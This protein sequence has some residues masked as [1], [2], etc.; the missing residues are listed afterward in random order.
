MNQILYSGKSNNKPTIVIV[1]IVVVA[2]L[3]VLLIG[4]AI[5]N[6]FNNKILR[7]VF[8]DNI[9]LSNMTKEQAIEAISREYS[10]SEG[11]EI[12]LTFQ[13][14][15]IAVNTQDIGFMHSD[16]KEI[17]EEA[18]N[19]GRNKNIFSNNFTVL[20]SYFNAKK[21][22]DIEEKIDKERLQNLLDSSIS[23]DGIFS[24]DDYYKISGDK[25]LIVRGTEGRKIDYDKLEVLLIDAIKSNEIY[26]EI[27]V[28]VSE[29]KP[30]DI[31]DVYAKV[32][33]E[34]VNASYKEGKEFEIILE[35]N[36]I[37]FDKEEA[38]EKYEELKNGETAEI[39][40]VITQPE[41]K[42]SDLG[43]ILFRTLLATHTSTYDVNDTSR[44]AN[45]E[46]ASNRCNNTILYPG[47]EFSFNKALGNRTIENGYKMGASFSGGKVVNTIGGGIC[48]VSSTIYNAALR[49]DL[50]IT[51]RKAHGM[52]VQY[53]PQSTDAT[54]VDN[55]VD[56]KFMNNRKYPVKIV[57]T[58]ENGVCTASIYG[59]KE[60]NE[61]TID[62]E[63]KILET[64]EYKTQKKN[65]SSI[66]KGITKVLQEPLNGYVS[67]AYKVYYKDG[68]EVDRKLI[69]KDTYEPINEIISVGTKSSSSKKPTK[70][71]TPT[72][73]P[74]PAPEPSPA[75]L[76]PPGWDN[77]ESGY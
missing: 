56:F 39:A 35:E 34:P 72:V 42:V 30:L 11:R 5:I 33:K 25:L 10:T 38:K 31:D 69:S 6:M 62:V 55:S 65:D 20:G 23:G 58:C 16:E 48:Q 53:V 60:E 13:D 37:E 27:P 68:V 4:F 71:S 19:Y 8:A 9:N 12:V 17:V 59:Y 61:P 54:V 75:P 40:L 70:P 76:L 57:T 22:I 67:E 3:V 46:I 41:I 73:S 74:T 77:P 64:L 44:V 50:E 28:I 43:D 45:L 18:Y 1:S 14:E 7:G 24:R 47:D 21:T 36:G 63:V 66:A 51:E 26:V 49:A 52:W 32:H 15:E 29:P 2:L